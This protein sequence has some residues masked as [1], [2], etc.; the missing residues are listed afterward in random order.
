[1][2]SVKDKNII[3]TGASGV[4]GSAISLALAKN[5]ARLAIL[6]RNEKKLNT[7][8]LKIS[9]FGGNHIHYTC[10]VLN[11]SELKTVNNLN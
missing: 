9:E 5:G 2:F 8:F 4:I 10:N 3:V 1:M 6:G 7:T 11:V